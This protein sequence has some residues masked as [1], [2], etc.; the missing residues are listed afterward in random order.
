M[1]RKQAT[2]TEKRLRLSMKLGDNSVV[3]LFYTDSFGRCCISTQMFETA[4]GKIYNNCDPSDSMATILL[5]SLT[6][7]TSYLV[8]RSWTQFYWLLALRSAHGTDPARLLYSTGPGMLRRMSH[9]PN[10]ST[11]TPL[12]NFATS[13][14]AR[15]SSLVLSDNSSCFNNSGSRSST[16]NHLFTQLERSQICS[17][18]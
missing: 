13:D 5:M 7:A 8:R 15:L 1:Y 4:H 2:G 18:S 10:T 3:E 6:A 12:T 16:V 17:L 9:W 11:W 14:S